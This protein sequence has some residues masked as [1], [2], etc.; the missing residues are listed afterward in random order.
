MPEFP[1]DIGSVTIKWTQD[2]YNR[3]CELIYFNDSSGNKESYAYYCKHGF[4]PFSMLLGN[5]LRRTT[6]VSWV[7][8]W[9]A[10]S[11][12]DRNKLLNILSNFQPTIGCDLSKLVIRAVNLIFYPRAKLYELLS[13]VAKGSRLMTRPWDHYRR[14]YAV[15][16]LELTSSKENIACLDWK[17]DTIH[18][19]NKNHGIE[20]NTDEQKSQYVDFFC[21]AIRGDEGR[22]LPVRKLEDIPLRE[23][24]KDNDLETYLS[25]AV[26]PQFDFKRRIILYG[27]ALFEAILE[28]HPNGLVEMLDY[29][30][31]FSILPVLPDE[32]HPAKD[33]SIFIFQEHK[34]LNHYLSK[35]CKT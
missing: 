28:V 2:P 14:A 26:I 20:L 13:P 4:F 1:F 23:K 9:D 27:D 3:D 32:T 33:D 17:A 10:V 30:E 19:F 18:H 22:F 35:R 12:E 6:P 11:T 16:D 25:G 21:W 31:K 8:R 24:F 29:E 15:A 5:I 34:I 7:P